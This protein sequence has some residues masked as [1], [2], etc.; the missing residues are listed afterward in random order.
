MEFCGG[1]SLQEIYHGEGQDSR[2]QGTA[3]FSP[4][5]TPTQGRKGELEPWIW[6]PVHFSLAV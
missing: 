5:P 1:G 6:A 2:A 4:S 3:A